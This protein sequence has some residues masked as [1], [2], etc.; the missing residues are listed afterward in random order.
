MAG[1]GGRFTDIQVFA[2]P[3][4]DQALASEISAAQVT[5]ASPGSLLS[6]QGQVTAVAF[7]SVNV[8]A[9]QQREPAGILFFDLTQPTNPEVL[10]LH[11][12]TRQDSGHSM[13]HITADAGIACA[14]CHPEAGD[15]A[16]L[17]TFE[18]IGARRTQNLRGGILG[19]EPFHWNGDMIDFPAL[20]DEVFVKRMS[21]LQP[22]PV[23]ANALA[24]WIDK[25]PALHATA[26]DTDAVERGRVL[27]ASDELGCVTCH[28]GTHLTNNQSA[29]VGTG[30]LLQVP[31][32]RGL[33]FRTP[34]L[35]NGCAKTVAERFGPCG[36]GDQH[37][38]TTQ[39]AAAQTQ[40]LTAYLESL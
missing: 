35:H 20:V 12:P 9:A 24:T 37:G 1:S 34:L 2:T 8:L 18:R 33:A 39:L 14:S 3:G 7:V 38:K 16:H 32:L 10:D 23:R 30:A 5:C 25:Q 26:P 29:H 11:E 28:S 36:G 19:T 17:W 27:F 40:D 31:S 21:G 15:D 22:D 6:A 13:F 4:P